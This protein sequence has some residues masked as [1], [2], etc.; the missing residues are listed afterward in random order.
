MYDV[1][2][3]F[4]ANNLVGNG[5]TDNTA[6]L[7]A[8]FAGTSSPALTPPYALYF[9]SGTYNFAS[10]PST[11]PALVCLF[12]DGKQ[13]TIINGTRTSVLSDAVFVF[14]N[15]V[16]IKDMHI[17]TPDTTN[18]VNQGLASASATNLV[19]ERVKIS[20]TAGTGLRA[21]GPVQVFATQ[22][23]FTNIYRLGSSSCVSGSIQNSTFTGCW[24]HDTNPS[25]AVNTQH[26]IYL[27]GA[28]KNVSIVNCAFQAYGGIAL[29]MDTLTGLTVT[30]CSFI[31]G[32]FSLSVM[33]GTDV[34]G[35]SFSDNTIT[36]SQGNGIN[37]YECENFAIVGN[38]VYMGSNG[39]SFV[40]FPP[41]STKSCNGRIVGNV[42][43]SPI[44]TMQFAFGV[45][46]YSGNDI[47][48]SDNTFTG[49]QMGVFLRGTGNVTLINVLRNDFIFP[50]GGSFSGSGGYFGTSTYGG[51]VFDGNNPQ[52]QVLDNNCSRMTFDM[53]FTHIDQSA[54]T[55]QIRFRAA[56]W[57][58]PVITLLASAAP[59]NVAVLS[60]ASTISPAGTT[61]R[62]FATSTT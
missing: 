51:V 60:S 33:D 8:I 25:A 20:N 19:L 37:L 12:G 7:N 61:G 22:C 42:V 50:L 21:A 28:P 10:Q 40:G 36:L 47:T 15:N 56:G 18:A 6:H 30:G 46:I 58:A 52:C 14:G 16:T 9:P 1:T 35:L 17:T 34:Y 27:N 23:E 43:T 57:A 5:S 59:T 11:I 13:Q 45:Q 41:N 4:A 55:D 26:C 48:I 2:T 49:I 53:L 62:I 39:A 32:A 24:F 31:D 3:D 44:N 38:N 54:N 29:E